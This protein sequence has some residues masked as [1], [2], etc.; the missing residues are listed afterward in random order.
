MKEHLKKTAVAAFAESAANFIKLQDIAD[1]V[2]DVG[3]QSSDTLKKG[4]HLF[5]CG[6]GGSA[7]DAQH[8]AAELVGRFLKE[9]KPLAATALSC[10]TSTLTA[11]GNDYGYDVV[12]SRQ[13]EGLA[14]A[15]DILFAFST[16]GNSKNIIKTVQSAKAMGVT[17]IGLTGS[18]GGELA[19]LCDICIKVP[20]DHTPRIQEMHIAVGHMV[21]E[22]IDEIY[23]A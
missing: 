16:S 13:L 4:G 17:A 7:A 6:N 22:I 10:N 14:K 9:R 5:F 20:S 12:F 2:V 11:V 23:L 18:K 8:L 21:C 3:M 1:V 19:K 15:G